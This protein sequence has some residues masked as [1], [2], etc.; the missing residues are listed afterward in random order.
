MTTDV[1]VDSPVST[2]VAT[3]FIS[4][5]AQVAVDSPVSSIVATGY[6]VNVSVIAR[7]SAASVLAVGSVKSAAIVA[8]MSPLA[9]VNAT[10]YN[11]DIL[12]T[13]TVTSTLSTVVA[14]GFVKTAD[15]P[16]V[17]DSPV[18]YVRASGKVLSAATVTGTITT[19]KTVSRDMQLPKVPNVDKQQRNWMDAVQAIINRR[20]LGVGNSTD[21]LVDL[22]DLLDAGVV[23]VG[24]GGNVTGVSPNV[25]KPPLV[26]GLSASGAMTTVILNWNAPSYSNFGLVE[27]WRSDNNNIGEAFK[28][29]TS[30]TNF[31][32]DAVG[33]GATKY[34]WVRSV[35]TAGVVGDFAADG[36]EGKTSLDPSYVMQLLTSQQWSPNITYQ[37]YQYVRGIPASPDDTPYPFQNFQYVCLVGG[38]SGT[39]EPT[40]PVVVGDT[41]TDG[42][43]TWQ[44]RSLTEKVPFTIGV[45]DGVPSVVMSQ[46][47][48]EDASI[49]TAK[50]H[51][52]AADKITAGTL[53]VGN[54]I[55]VGSKLWGGFSEY[56]NPGAVSGF[57]VGMDGGLP[58]L[59]LDTGGPTLTR[60]YIRFNGETISMN[61]D[62]FSG[63]DGYFDDLLGDSVTF[64]RA[65]FGFLAV[66]EVITSSDKVRESP[67]IPIS[68]PEFLNYLC[69]PTGVR[70]TETFASPT[71]VIGIGY[72]RPFAFYQTG[73]YS[74]IVPYDWADSTTKYRAK[75]KN[76]G[77]SI[78]IK[79]Q[80]AGICG[81]NGGA[82][83]A[84]IYIL[85]G[86]QALPATAYNSD[87]ATDG[88]PSRFLAKIAL[89]NIG[90]TSP[91]PQTITATQNMT[92]SE[93][94]I[95]SVTAEGSGV[96]TGGTRGFGT[97]TFAIGNE[98]II[99][100]PD[101]EEWLD[102]TG[103]NR[104]KVAIVYKADYQE[105]PSHDATATGNI[106]IDFQLD[107]ITPYGS[108]AD[109]DPSFVIGS[110][111]DS[112]MID[113]RLNSTDYTTL[114]QLI[115]DS[116]RPDPL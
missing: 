58:R 115:R 35:S 71:L 91:E 114:L 25:T 74:S 73:T 51:D 12:A 112:V 21:R 75:S 76:I 110:E 113:V 108:N 20:V 33:T 64:N 54:D 67:V 4:I 87:A 16:I 24:A 43:I 56:A 52:L 62:I 100:C 40:W 102:Y 98:L 109:N 81:S 27:I 82:T 99:R 9:T 6:S 17:V 38:I 86:S 89:T 95:F 30:V 48:I 11:F 72:S 50:I 7:S 69:F 85:N 49:N 10:G 80:S 14:T 5:N 29:G 78:R 66:D 23:G 8:P 31:F 41:V 26:T 61:V 22:R 101:D 1:T 28:V 15:A 79:A 116:Q 92:G 77:F 42:T 106:E 36:V 34:Y 60:K 94:P 105:G 90:V 45:V 37:A 55:Q 83:Y 111:A 32:Q 104:L 103:S 39:T 19:V 65:S 47:F 93:V 70:K 68:E 57:W 59:A 84:D 13:G 96:V 3:G 53:A 63:A 2:I 44:C 18:A 88:I 46:A 97:P 107:T